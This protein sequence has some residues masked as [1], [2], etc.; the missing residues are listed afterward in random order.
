MYFLPYSNFVIETSL[1]KKTA[2]QNLLSNV[3]TY[4]GS[5]FSVKSPKNLFRGDLYGDSFRIRRILSYRNDFIPTIKG[6]FKSTDH[7]T[8]IV[9]SMTLSLHVYIF[10]I[11]WLAV[12]GNGIISFFIND[13]FTLFQLLLVGQSLGK[14]RVQPV[15]TSLE[16]F[17]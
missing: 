1:D 12:F 10:V 16:S 14:A 11:F 3:N 6:Q 15:T 8:K 4:K 7:G 13:D 17:L 5:I 2:M 9:I